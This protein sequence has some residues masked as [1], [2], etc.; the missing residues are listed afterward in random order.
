MDFL[1]NTYDKLYDKEWV[2]IDK[3]TYQNKLDEHNAREKQN[4]LDKLDNMS[5]DKRRLYSVNQNISTGVMYKESEKENYDFRMSKEYEQKTIDER[6]EMQKELYEE[7]D[8][9]DDPVMISVEEDKDDQE[10]YFDESDFVAEGDEDED[11]L[12]ALQLDHD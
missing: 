8:I 1:I 2:F 4:N 11:D 7:K 12:D 6:I 10:G 9:T 3:E 5:D